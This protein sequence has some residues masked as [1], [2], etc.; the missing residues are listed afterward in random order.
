VYHDYYRWP[1]RDRKVFEGWLAN[2]TWGH[3]FQEYH[4]KGALAAPAL[5]QAAS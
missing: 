2:T 5:A 3:L 1:A 4:L